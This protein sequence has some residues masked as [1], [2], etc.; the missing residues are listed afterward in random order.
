MLFGPPPEGSTPEE[1]P[2]ERTC[3]VC[4]AE[5]KPE[6][7]YCTQCGAMPPSA[8]RFCTRC[9]TRLD[10]S[11][12]FCTN[13]GLDVSGI[14]GAAHMPA[15]GSYPLTFEVEYAEKLS[16]FLIFVKWILAIPQ[17]LVVYAL[18]SVISV[19]TFI[20][21][22]AILFT[23]K[24]PLGLF[25]LVVGFTRWSANVTAYVSL[26]RDEYPPFAMDAGRFPLTYDVEYPQR[27]SRWLIF[28]KILLVIPNQFVLLFLSIASWFVSFIAWWAILFTGRYPRGLFD[29]NVGVL[30]WGYRASAYANLMRD[31]YPPY[32]T[33]SDARPS[34]GKAIA[35]GI[36]AGILAIVGMIGVIAALATIDPQTEVVRV[37]YERL[38]SGEVSPSVRIEGTRVVL[39][40]VE[41]PYP[42]GLDDAAPGNRLVGFNMTIAN[43]D[44]AFTLVGADSFEL[45]DTFGET[46]SPIDDPLNFESLADGQRVR[47]VVVFEIDESADPASLTYSPGFARFG[48]IGERVRFEF[49]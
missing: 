18:G 3:A 26:F 47:L 12:R 8:G 19:I 17:F 20:A 40:G 45:E 37:D 5:L 7:R 44:S 9:G 16:R 34:G 36:G 43:E 13:C 28:F 10:P 41:D 25:N 31:E 30:R 48:P 49:H 32:S 14:T 23:G 33:R 1:P 21:W 39:N 29:F 27:L 11:F 2:A 4:G 22:F 35:V 15:P 6:F 24:Y 38:E 46:D 42:G